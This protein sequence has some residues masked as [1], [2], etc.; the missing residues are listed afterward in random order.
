MVRIYADA[1]FA[2][3]EHEALGKTPG[4]FALEVRPSRYAAAELTDL[5]DSLPRIEIRPEES[6]GASYRAE[7]DLFVLEGNVPPDVVAAQFGDATYRYD[8]TEDDPPRRSTRLND[9]APHYGGAR[10]VQGGSSCS[11]GFT[12][13]F[14]DG[15]NRMLTAGHCGSLGQAFSSPGG[16]S[17]GTISHRLPFP[18]YDVAWIS[19]TSYSGRIYGGGLTGTAVVVGSPGANPGMYGN[20]CTSGSYSHEKCG[21]SVVDMSY[22]LCD[23]SGCTPNLVKADRPGGATLNGDSGGPFYGKKPG[24]SKAY[25]RGIVTGSSSTSTIVTPWGRIVSY[26]TKMI[27][28]PG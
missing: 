21:Y 18:L 4:D 23:I 6:F 22:E 19:G 5:Y 15:V 26:Y 20:Y 8:F 28:V 13:T 25:A 3:A 14:Q 24:D 9:V 27:I 2:A 7:L 16:A 1:D 12:T 17:F 10:T 11:T